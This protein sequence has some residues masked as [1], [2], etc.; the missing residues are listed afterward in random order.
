MWGHFKEFHGIT[1]KLAILHNLEMKLDGQ[2]TVNIIEDNQVVDTK[3]LIINISS[4]GN[5]KNEGW[6]V[7][8]LTVDT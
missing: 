3:S 7:F 8:R 2:P 6:Y 5:Y 4:P 1:K